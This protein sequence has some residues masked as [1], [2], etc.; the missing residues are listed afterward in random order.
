MKTAIE[1]GDDNPNKRVK[2][3]KCMTVKELAQLLGLPDTS[4]IKHLFEKM[5]LARTVTMIVEIDYAKQLAGELGDEVC[6]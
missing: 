2:I 4:I 1:L 3:D 5:N 6:D